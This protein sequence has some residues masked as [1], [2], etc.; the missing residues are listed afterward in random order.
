MVKW[1]NKCNGQVRANSF[2]NLISEVYWIIQI[3]FSFLV[4]T[5]VSILK[6]STSNVSSI[7]YE[8]KF[9][10]KLFS[11]NSEFL[12]FI[13]KQYINYTIILLTNLGTLLLFLPH[14]INISS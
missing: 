12:Y 7:F 4:T 8:N 11:L 9:W 1:W 2:A 13:Y 5:V 3:L 10:N 6:L 14:L